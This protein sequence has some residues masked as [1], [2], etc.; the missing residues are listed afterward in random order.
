MGS[1]SSADGARAL[2][3]GG[4]QGYEEKNKTCAAG[5]A[6]AATHPT[7]WCATGLVAGQPLHRQP[8]QQL[9]YSS[10]RLSRSN[11]FSIL[12]LG[13]SSSSN[14]YWREE[15]AGGR[16]ERRRFEASAARGRA[17]RR[18]AAAAARGVQR[19]WAPAAGSRG[20]GRRQRAAALTPLARRWSATAPVVL[21]LSF[22]SCRRRRE[23]S[24]GVVL[25]QGKSGLPPGCL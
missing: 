16:R 12:V 9:L 5:G 11:G 22:P 24:E 4:C 2:A 13:A 7:R 21:W 25:N 8:G 3:S 10:T 23:G 19:Q 20:S 17:Q 14:T 1:G 15:S 18:G 6:A